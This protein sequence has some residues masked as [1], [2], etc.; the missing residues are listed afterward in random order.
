MASLRK[1][2]KQ[3][4]LHIEVPAELIKRR[5][6]QVLVHSC[7]YYELNDNVISDEVFDKWAKELEQLH[8]DHPQYSDEWDDAFAKWDSS[9]G[10]DLPHRHPWVYGKA[11]QV[12]RRNS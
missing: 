4:E 1:F 11:T 12:L 10:Y 9:S 7:I 5:R 2:A 6:L 8:K 3:S